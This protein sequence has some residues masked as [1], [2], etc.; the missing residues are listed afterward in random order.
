VYHGSLRIALNLLSIP[1]M[2][3]GCE[4]VFLPAKNLITDR[5]NGVKED[6]IQAYTLLR[7]WLEEVD[8]K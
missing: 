2:S 6:I 3:V 4:R 1:L 7:H 8:F 5:R